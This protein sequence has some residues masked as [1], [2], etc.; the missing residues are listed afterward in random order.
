MYHY[1]RAACLALFGFTKEAASATATILPM[2]MNARGVAASEKALA[3]TLNKVR[4]S[5]RPAPMG[6]PED[7]YSAFLGRERPGE[8]F[9]SQAFRAQMSNAITDSRLERLRKG[10]ASSIQPTGAS[11]AATVIPPKVATIASDPFFTERPNVTEI[12]RRSVAKQLESA[13]HTANA[14]SNVMPPQA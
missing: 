7:L 13:K 2:A 1:G 4:E 5:L 9:T 12:S 11:E 10:L 14:L 6:H 8:S 3:N